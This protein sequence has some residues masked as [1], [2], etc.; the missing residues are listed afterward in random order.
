MVKE[1]PST[2]ILGES[3]AE[4]KY[5]ISLAMIKSKPP[6]GSAV[7]PIKKQSQDQN[8]PSLRRWGSSSG[9]AKLG[10]QNCLC[11]PTTHAGSFRCRHHRV[12]S[13]TRA[14]SIGSNLA[15][16][17]SSKSS[18]FSDTLKAQ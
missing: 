6:S 3:T 7:E 16:L 13:L 1:N 8:S 18:R 17:L 10:R 14:G 4:K 11:S 15:V 5:S 2:L 9:S 12:E